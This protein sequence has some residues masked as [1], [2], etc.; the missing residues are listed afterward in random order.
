MKLQAT[1]QWV[2]KKRKLQILVFLSL[3]LNTFIYD[4]FFPTLN[5][6]RT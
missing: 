2:K 5:L 6:T 1:L 4:P 3:Q